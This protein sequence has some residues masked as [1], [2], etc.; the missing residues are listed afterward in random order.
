MALDSTTE[1]SVLF[2][3]Q[4]A[5]DFRTAIRDTMQMGVPQDSALR[6]TFYFPVTTSYPAGTILDSEGRPIDPRIQGTAHQKEA[7]Q[8]PCTVEYASDT[9]NQGG[10]V[11]TNWDGRAVITIFDID[12]TLVADAIE[13]DLSGKRYMIQERTATGLGSCTVYQLLCFQK[14]VEVA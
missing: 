6:P 11:G 3:D 7:E 10:L 13:V 8:P 4:D 1:F 14:G 5:A 2:N 12:Y 9:T